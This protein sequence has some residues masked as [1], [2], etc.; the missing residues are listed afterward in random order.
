MQMSFYLL[1]AQ[2]EI[3]KLFSS[4]PSLSDRIMVIFKLH[5][6]YVINL[7]GMRPLLDFSTARNSATALIHSKLGYCSSVFCFNLVSNQLHCLQ[8]IRNSSAHAV[9]KT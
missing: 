7:E 8:L 2:P 9:S 4:N 6:S 3:W 1:L 5:L